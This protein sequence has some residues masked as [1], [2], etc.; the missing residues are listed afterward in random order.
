MRVKR[1]GLVALLPCCMVLAVASAVVIGLA[2]PAYCAG[3]ESARYI[4]KVGTLAPK[5][6][7]WAKQ[8]EEIIVPAIAEASNNQIR[9]KVFWGGAIGDDESYISKMKIGQIQAAG[10]SGQGARVACP[11]FAVVELPFLFRNYDEVDYVRDH[12]IHTFDY[13]FAQKGLKLA[14][15]I[16][17]D[18]D[19]FYSR[20]SPLATLEDFRGLRVSAWYGPVETALLEALGAQPVPLSVPQIADAWH[21]GT[22]DAGISPAIWAVGAQ[23]YSMARYVNT[24][25][26]RYSPAVIVVSLMAWNSVPQAF[27]DAIWDRRDEITKRFTA[28]TRQDNKKSLAAMLSY[29][30]RETVMTQANLAKLKSRAMTVYDTLADREYPSDLLEEVS[31]Y[32]QAYRSGKGQASEPVWK[33]KG[34]NGAKQAAWQ[35]R[36][37]QVSQVQDRLKGLGL[38]SG[39]VD[40]VLGPMSFDAIRKYQKEKGLRTSGAIDR[41]LM[42]SLGIK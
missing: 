42:D 32:L 10:L 22:I 2:A 35:E 16:D 26:L 18:F 3:E 24:V 19:Q 21:A 23:L 41:S 15:W 31:R 11:E 14:F 39:T 1:A 9:L 13:Y 4:W 40:G 7:G 33:A 28:G 27:R 34:G 17:Q 20:K 36:R 37:H 5:G 29:G 6:I 30:V 25:K 8:V 12:M 38:Y